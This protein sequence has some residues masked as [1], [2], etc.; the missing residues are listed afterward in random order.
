M[1]KLRYKTILFDMDGTIA[2]TDPMIVATFNDLYDKYRGGKRRPPEELYYFS[3][4]P[5]KETLANEFPELD[6]KEIL[7]EFHDLSRSY[8]DTCIFPYPNCKEVLTELKNSGVHLGVVTNKMHDLALVVIDLLNL[9]GLFDVVIGSDDVIHTKPHQEGMLKA[10]EMVGGSIKETLYVGDNPSDL[11]C[12]NNANVDCCLVY[13]GPRVLPETL[14]PK[15][16]INS[17][18]ELLEEVYE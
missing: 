12:A 6:Q 13:W 17:Y 14:S 9:N 15:I 1:K 18:P 7:H 11:M 5:I 8:Y 4:P 3:G 10:I 16:K 2:D